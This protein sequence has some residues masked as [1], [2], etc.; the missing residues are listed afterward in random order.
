[1]TAKATKKRGGFVR[2][3][4]VRHT[5]APCVQIHSV[6]YNDDG[7]GAKTLPV[8]EHFSFEDMTLTGKTCNLDHEWKTCDPINLRFDPSSC[9]HDVTVNGKKYL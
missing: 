4:Y 5:T 6:G 8:L 1:M 2:N 9:L 3:V 7:E